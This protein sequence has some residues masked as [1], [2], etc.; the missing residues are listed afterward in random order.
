MWHP[1]H[2]PITTTILCIFIYIAPYNQDTFAVTS[3][4]VLC[5]IC[6]ITQVAQACN[7]SHILVNLSPISLDGFGECPALGFN[8]LVLLNLNSLLSNNS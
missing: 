7:Q 6:S 1:D 2:Q 3:P 5:W 8:L 4:Y